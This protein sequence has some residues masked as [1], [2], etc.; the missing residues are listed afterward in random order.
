MTFQHQKQTYNV[1]QV[2]LRFFCKSISAALFLAAA[3]IWTELSWGITAAL[4]GLSLFY[5]YLA[6]REF[7]QLRYHA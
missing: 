7:Q 5:L 4:L 6:N 3:I 2:K 1:K